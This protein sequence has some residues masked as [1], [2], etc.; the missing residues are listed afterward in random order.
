MLANP[1]RI[2]GSVDSNDLTH[3]YPLS[4]V[5]H[6]ATWDSSPSVQVT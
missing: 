2:C 4:V 3:F 6:G 1:S 5:M